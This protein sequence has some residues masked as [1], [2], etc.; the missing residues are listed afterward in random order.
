M[1]LTEWLK[2][3]DGRASAL[4]RHCGVSNAA[5]SQWQTNGVPLHQLRKVAAFTCGEVRE[6]DLIADVL[7]RAES[8]AAPDA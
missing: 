4:A 7:E 2:A 6:L 1:T 5:V 8:R 3:Q